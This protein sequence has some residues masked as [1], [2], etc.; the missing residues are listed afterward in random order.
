MNNIIK[1]IQEIYPDINGGFVYWETKQDGSLWDNPIDGLKWENTEY[2]KPSWSDIEA[3]LI[4]ISLKESKEVKK[5]LIKSHRDTQFGELLVYKAIDG[6]DLYLKPKPQENIFLAALAMA[7]GTTKDWYPY[8]INCVKQSSLVAITK[9]DLLSIAAHYETRKTTFY[10]L[11]NE[12][13]FEI[14]ALNTIE[15]VEAYDINNITI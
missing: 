4:N 6:V 3:K 9:E 11:C 5:Q 1:A 2:N 14:D 12:M 8:D 13:C 7:D 10:N 15:E